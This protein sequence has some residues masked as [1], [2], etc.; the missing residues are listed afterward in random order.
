MSGI[1]MR[2][3]EWVGNGALKNISLGF[4]PHFIKMQ[5]ITDGTT[6]LEYIDGD[7]GVDPTG[8]LTVVGA[9]GP[10]T[11][12][13]AIVPYAGDNANARG[14]TVNAATNVNAKT[15]RYVAFGKL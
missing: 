5:N 13:G 11:A 7:S 6:V 1:K 14:F 12:A 3:G 9:A 10:V 15:F 2:T 8:A 4:K